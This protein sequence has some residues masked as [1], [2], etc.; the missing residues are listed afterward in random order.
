MQEKDFFK[1]QI[2][3]AESLKMKKKVFGYKKVNLSAKTLSLHLNYD[4]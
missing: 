2:T 4:Y 3:L 1:F